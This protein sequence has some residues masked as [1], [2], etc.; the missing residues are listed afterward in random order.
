VSTPETLVVGAGPAGLAAARCLQKR[1][2][3]V[4]VI[5]RGGAVGHSWRN[6]Y[7]RLHLHTVREQSHLPD[8][9]MPQHWPRYVS[10]DQVVEY[11]EDY[12]R[13]FHITPR[14]GVEVERIAPGG[15]GW[16]TRLADGGMLQSTHVVLAT[17]MNRVSVVP[18]WPGLDHTSIPVMHSR[19]YRTAE[20]FAGARVLVV[21]IGNTGAEIALDLCDHG[22]SATIAVRGPV[23]IVSRDTFGRPIQSTALALQRWPPALAGLVG[24]VLQRLSVGRLD[25]WGLRRPRASP[26][27]QIQLTGRTPTI[28]VG[29]VARIK[30]GDITVVPGIRAFDGAEI[31]FDDGTR[32]AYDQVIL[33]TGYRP[34]IADLVPEAAAMLDERGY[35]RGLWGEGPL[36][37]LSW[38]G[39]RAYDVGGILRSIRLDAEQIATHI[40]DSQRA[41]RVRGLSSGP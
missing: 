18:D 3:D 2:V 28:D 17:G 23:N 37:G 26:G 32:A 22:A 40:A 31:E 4:L 38:L 14:F 27:R 16:T 11:L 6:H 5:E 36:A 20:P 34:D 41:R 15:S 13:H 12:A 10:R 21:G 30:R 8:R 24:R 25:R 39:F 19:Q 7:R 35:P 29:T 33:A 1:G 9:P